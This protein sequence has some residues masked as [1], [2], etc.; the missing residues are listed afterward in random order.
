MNA[1]FVV[2][3]WNSGTTLLIDVL[4]KHPNLSLRKARYKPNLE[5]RTIKKILNKLGADFWD[6]SDTYEEVVQNGFKN[7]HEPK[8]SES[9]QIR[10]KKIFKWHFWVRKPKILLL[11]NPYLFYF[12]NFINTTFKEDNIKKVIILRNNTYTIIIIFFW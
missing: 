10:F 3:F 7:Y 5:E 9:Q 11:K 12:Y 2:G 4:Q 8:L 1:L 6:F